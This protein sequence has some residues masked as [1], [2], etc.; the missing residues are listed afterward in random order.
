MS[1]K[2]VVGSED[3]DH[4]HFHFGKVSGCLNIFSTIEMVVSDQTF[5]MFFVYEL[6]GGANIFYLKSVWQD[7]W[8]VTF[9]IDHHDLI[10]CTPRGNVIG[11]NIIDGDEKFFYVNRTDSS[12]DRLMMLSLSL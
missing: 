11:S 8:S 5:K 7:D 4:P 2:T 12:D 9:G 1:N 6:T 3:I 10:S